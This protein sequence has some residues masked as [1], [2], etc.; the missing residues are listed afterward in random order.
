MR[1]CRNPKCG[2]MFTP[3]SGIHSFCSDSCRR[4]VRGSEYRRA[5]QIALYRDE[6]VCTGCADTNNLET[7]HRQPLCMGGDN[8]VANLQT[9]CRACHKTKHRS[10][11]EAIRH[12]DNRG[13]GESQEH[14]YA[15]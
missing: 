9:L 3:K 14:N 5:R 7:H 8:S 11:K 12:Y 6:F 1:P 13:H 4:S 15:A 2:Q 10:W